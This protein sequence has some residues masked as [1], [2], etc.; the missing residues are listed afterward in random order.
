MPHLHMELRR[1]KA[2]ALRLAAATDIEGRPLPSA[3]ENA[4]GHSRL[5]WTPSSPP[6]MR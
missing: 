3:D 4:V 2:L 5:S 1:R 6:P